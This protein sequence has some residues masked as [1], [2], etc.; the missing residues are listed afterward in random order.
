MHHNYNSIITCQNSKIFDRIHYHTALYLIYGLVQMSI[1]FASSFIYLALQMALLGVMDGVLICFI[2]PIA[3]DLMDSLIN[4]KMK[5]EDQLKFK[6]QLVNQ[7]IGYYH[8]FMAP[9]SI[10]MLNV[11]YLKYFQ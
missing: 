6:R 7:A 2:V 3:C 4:P 8:A 11:L 5:I 10:G 1:P 9:M